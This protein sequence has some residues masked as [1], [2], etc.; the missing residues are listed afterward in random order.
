MLIVVRGSMIVAPKRVAIIGGGLTGSC[1]TNHLRSLLDDSASVEII[2]FD[3]GGRGPGGR[4]SHRRVRRCGKTRPSDLMKN[5]SGKFAILTSNF[6]S[7]WNKK[8]QLF[9]PMTCSYSL[10]MQLTYFNSITVASSSVRWTIDLSIKSRPGRQQELPKNGG[11]N[12]LLLQILPASKDFTTQTM[13]AKMSAIMI[14]CK[15]CPNFLLFIVF[16]LNC[17]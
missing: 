8:M 7:F 14:S 16:R 17:I 10:L 6:I 4:A 5:F 13:T 12:A 11:E 1:A 3:Q 15:S 2:L 9:Y